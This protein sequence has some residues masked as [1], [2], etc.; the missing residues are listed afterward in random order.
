MFTLNCNGR[1]V[2]LDKPLVMGII[3][4][5]PDSFYEGSRVNELDNVLHRAEKMLNEGA[6][7]LDMGAQSTRPGSKQIGAEE[8]LERVVGFI[9]AVHNQFP[10]AII[11]VDTYH[12]R[13]A[14]AAVAAGAAMVND[15]SGGN[16][17]ASMLATVGKLRV[18]YV[19]MHVKG[20]PET[21]HQRIGYDNITRDIIDYFITRIRLCHEA[22]IN[23][24]I[25]DPGFGFSKNSAQ[26]MKLLTNLELLNMLG[27]PLLA[28][29]SRKSTIYKTLGV[30]AGEA[31]N[32]STVLNTICL[33]KGASILR[34]HDVKE[35]VEAVTL[36]EAL[37][38]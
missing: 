32:G 17:D 22:G 6:T 15:I 33:V 10:A 5:T 27:K 11:S 29:I 21:M 26:N 2:M 25:I 30:T 7:F 20:T 8:E 12:A 36:V 13:V 31:L 16:A 35:A 4:V 9:S 19:C 24:V 37:G 1:L 28:G 34:V 14:A 3:N 23:D 38:V 18:P